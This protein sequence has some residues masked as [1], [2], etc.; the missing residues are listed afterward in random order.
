[1]RDSGKTRD[2]LLEELVE[3]RQRVAALEAA[4]QSR[5]DRKIGRD[6]FSKWSPLGIHEC[7][8]EGRITFVNPAQ[9]AI[10]GYSAD[11]LLGTYVWDRIGAGGGEGGDGAAAKSLAA[12]QPLPSP[13]FARNVRK[14]GEI[15]DIRVDWNYR[16]DSQGQVVGFVSIIS[17]VTEQKRLERELRKSQA[18]LRA[19]IDCLPFDFFALG[20]DGRYILQNAASKEHW[21]DGTGKTP[22]EVCQD[23]RELANW[24][25]NNRRAYAGEKFE[26][27]TT[28]FLHGEE[29]SCL[30]VLAPIQD[31]E[32]TYGILGVNF[33]LTKRKRAEE[34]LRQS[35]QRYRLLTEST[36][37]MIFILNRSGDVL[38]ANRSAATGI[39]HDA[40]ELV[41]LRQDQLFSPEEVK[42]HL[43][44]HRRC[45]RDG[46]GLRRGWIV[47]VSAASEVWL[48]TRLMPLRDDSG[49]ITA[50]MGVAR[51][52]TGR[53]RTEAAL[54]QARDELEKRVAERTAQLAEANRALR[55]SCTELQATCNRLAESEA[56]YRLLVE[57]TGT[58]C[59][60][61]IGSGFDVIFC[62]VEGCVEN[63][64]WENGGELT[65][66]EKAVP[67]MIGGH[68][69]KPHHGRNGKWPTQGSGPANDGGRNR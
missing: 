38:Y 9:E 32:E 29:R 47:P 53:K 4:E 28:F 61:L 41:G 34:A 27:E 45:V 40:G 3:L 19:T 36:T 16:R 2:Q 20:P 67:A 30:A 13:F 58:Q 22:E 11:E 48:N 39:R 18:M 52:I 35:E 65:A 66:H 23:P 68:N 25:D 24:L 15:F 60:G 6:S 54:E 14:N 21:G 44:Q 1:M 56:K 43:K 50:V 12:E 37:D 26:R 5:R 17:D 33:D 7:D 31:G 57:T 62:E 64:L 55:Q 51:N 59:Q 69:T 46:Q 49:E 8:T 42:K 63:V 10:T